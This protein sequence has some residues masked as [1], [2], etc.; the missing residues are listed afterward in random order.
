M[1]DRHPTGDPRVRTDEHHG[2][3]RLCRTDRRPLSDRARPGTPR[4]RRAGA[5]VDHAIGWWCHRCEGRSRATG[6]HRRVRAGGRRRGRGLPRTA[7]PAAR[8]HHVRHGGHDHQGV[9]DR[10]RAS[11]ADVRV[12]GWRRHQPEQ[13]A[14]E[15]GRLRAEATAHRRVGDRRRRRQHRLD[16]RGRRPAGWAPERRSPP[17]ARLLRYRRPRGDRHG[18]ACRPRLY[19][20]RVARRRPRA[21]RRRPGG[22]DRRGASRR[23]PWSDRSSRPRTGASGSPSRR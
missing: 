20:S 6:T 11:P 2:D 19:Q 14:G 8:H 15:G 21:S 12:R 7:Y 18:R 1:L 17:R 3:Q 9:D 5:A 22:E 16:R 13:P 4:G 10:G 23:A